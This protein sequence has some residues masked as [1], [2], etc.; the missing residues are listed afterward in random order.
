MF[1]TMLVKEQLP[2]IDQ[3]GSVK[4]LFKKKRRNG[5]TYLTLNQKC[6]QYLMISVGM[7]A[8]N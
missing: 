2:V 4:A 5:S 1:A 7:Y 3:E 6:Q 8:D